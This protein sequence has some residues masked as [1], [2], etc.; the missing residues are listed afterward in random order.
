M[1]RFFYFSLIA[2]A[3]MAFGGCQEKEEDL[4]EE[5][6]QEQERT[7]T[8]TMRAQ[9]VDG[10]ETKGLE[11]GDG[12]SLANTQSLLNIWE[13]YEYVQVYLGDVLVGSLRAEP[14]ASDAHYATLT[15][16]LTTTANIV[17]G[18]TR[19]TLISPVSLD[20]W[21]YTGQEGVLE[22]V[23]N[24]DNSIEAKYNVVMAEN[25][26]VTNVDGDNITTE[27]ALFESQ[28]SIYRLSF[29]FQKGGEGTK[30]PITAQRVTISA[31]NGGLWRSNADGTGDITVA[32]RNATT[33]PFFV[34]L[35]NLNTTDAEALNFQ[36]V[37]DGGY[38]YLGS[39]TIPAELKA[40]GTFV[41]IK[42]AT[43]TGRLGIT[44]STESVD[45]AL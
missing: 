21:S 36:V 3:A 7:W 12:E 8:L 14:D 11:I 6:P 35:R 34:A 44:K 24:E 31:A 28:Q 41:S 42:N 2:M 20:S 17:A 23:V 39:K 1:K 27:Q 30:N 19:L 32:L 26:L 38:T 37:D 18:T 13:G 22:G 25:V 10:P 15:G 5:Q 9:R 29:R 43:L 33:D 45:E 16:S 4:Q 40:N